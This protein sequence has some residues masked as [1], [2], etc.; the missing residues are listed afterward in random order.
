MAVALLVGT[1]L[2]DTFAALL[3]HIDIILGEMASNILSGCHDGRK[4]TLGPFSPSF[5]PHALL[6][7][8]LEKLLPED[9]HLQVG[10]GDTNES[11][12]HSGFC[13]SKGD[14]KARCTTAWW[15]SIIRSSQRCAC[16]V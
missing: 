1:P 6:R 5:D 9:G 14:R 7:E 3:K 12:G 10:Q 8:G 13:E 15:R 11:G 16:T 2:G 4:G